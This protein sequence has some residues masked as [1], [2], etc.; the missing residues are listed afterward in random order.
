MTSEPIDFYAVLGL[1]RTATPTQISAA[2]RTALRRYHPD[3]RTVAETSSDARSDTA[4]QQVLT[5]YAV[6]HDPA[7]R[8]A[9]DQRTA[10]R[11]PRTRT[12][13]SPIGFPRTRPVDDPPLRAGPVYWTPCPTPE[14]RPVDR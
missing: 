11:S 9:Y 6:L 10:P 14:S 12:Q 7:R 8:L 3:T 13:P 5:A 2:Y 4:L 1:T